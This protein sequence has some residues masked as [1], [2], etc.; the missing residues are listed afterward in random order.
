MLSIRAG[1]AIFARLVQICEGEVSPIRVEALSDAEIKSIGTANSKVKAIRALTEAIITQELNLT[2]L[3][4][5]ND[6]EV[7]DKLME[8]RGIGWWTAK[9][10]LIFV[11]D[12]PDVLPFEDVAF[13][14]VFRWLYKNDDV[15]KASIEKKCK[16]WKPYS[17]IAARYFYRAL[18]SGLTGKE[19]HLY[20]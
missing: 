12:R 13:Q 9:M 5:C 18:D 15:S 4:E 11:L 10:Y 16:K 19:F 20:K 6:D 3:A 1:K 8:I 7:I 2:L 14:Q 17:S